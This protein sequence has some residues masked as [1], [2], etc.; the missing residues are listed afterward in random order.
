MFYKLSIFLA[1][2]KPSANPKKIYVGDLLANVRR[3]E[4]E[5]EF[6]QFGRIKD[7]WIAQNPPGFAFVE[8]EEE[9]D[10]EKA[11]RE[12]DGK[13]V[14]GTRVRV[15]VSKPPE[16]VGRGSKGAG[17][18]RTRGRRGG[19]PQGG[20][21][22]RLGATGNRDRGPPSPP[23]RRSSPPQRRGASPARRRQ[24]SPIPPLM[25]P[26]RRSYSPPPLPGSH[27]DLAVKERDLF[28]RYK[29]AYLRDRAL[30]QMA[31]RSSDSRLLNA[32]L[33]SGRRSPPPPMFNN[34]ARSPHRRYPPGRPRP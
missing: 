14:C 4:L 32:V 15:E 17:N 29:D 11:V 19:R 33:E 24:Q 13:S 12:M 30:L 3:D 25:A 27:R 1:T 34:R 20:I 7:I 21:A 16:E 5:A 22:S 2:M 9:K 8:Y 6:G 26:R 31:H 18:R 10:A 23:R 28:E